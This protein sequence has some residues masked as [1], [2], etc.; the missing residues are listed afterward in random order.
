MN[1]FSDADHD[2]RASAAEALAAIGP[3]A[4]GSASALLPLARSDRIG[5]VRLQAVRALGRVA[6]PTEAAQIFLAARL[7]EDEWPAV[8]AA[9]LDALTLHRQAARASIAAI[10]RAG[11]DSDLDVRTAAARALVW[12]GATP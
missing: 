3:P 11:R 1:A 10:R 2:V 8:R 9:A 12:A 5:W 7:K 4:A 6:E